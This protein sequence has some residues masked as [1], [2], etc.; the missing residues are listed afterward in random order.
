MWESIRPDLAQGAHA[1]RGRKGGLPNDQS[2]SPYYI[3][4]M[5]SDD[6]TTSILS[7]SLICSMYK[8]FSE[9]ELL[10]GDWQEVASLEGS[11]QSQFTI[12][13]LKLA[14]QIKFRVC[15]ENENGFSDPIVEPV[16]KKISGN[17]TIKVMVWD[18]PA[19]QA[20]AGA[21]IP[22]NIC[23]CPSLDGRSNILISV[24]WTLREW[25]SHVF[26]TPSRSLR[27]RIRTPSRAG[28]GILA[29]S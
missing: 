28:V 29:R 21:D 3:M 16:F 18:I 25:C 11:K 7:R 5:T 24:S 22:R 6:Y 17:T 13:G 9:E 23:T 14:T 1:Q 2:R 19:I 26:F 10:V 4:T 15:A 12:Y 20:R 8:L 27:T